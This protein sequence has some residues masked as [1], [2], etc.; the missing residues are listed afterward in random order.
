MFFFFSP[1]LQDCPI[2]EVLT[3]NAFVK[4]AAQLDLNAPTTQSTGAD[5]NSTAESTAD[6]TAE[7]SPTADQSPI[8]DQSP[9]AE[10]SAAPSPAPIDED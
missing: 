1:F 10:S 9:T 4:L 8:A 5:Q 6:P 2:K 3:R 7:Q